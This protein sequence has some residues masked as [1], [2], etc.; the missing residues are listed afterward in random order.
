MPR[1][2][3]LRHGNTFDPGEVVTR[4]GGRTDPP[5]SKSGR[6]Q[7]AAVAEALAGRG[8][9]IG[10]ILSSPLARAVETAEAVRA[11]LAPGLAIERAEALREIDYGPDEN[12]PEADVVAR[13]GGDAL[14]AW[15]AHA[16]PA[17]GWIVDPQSLIAA[18]RALFADVAK[19][20]G[21]TLAVTSNGVARFA[22]DAADL[23]PPDAPRR[24]KTAAFGIVE[25]GAGPCRVTD[26]NLPC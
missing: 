20:S 7:S 13:V 26:W 18:W 19:A 22:L 23:V 11:R 3:I 21:D 10:R 6:A 9:A 25:A 15:D 8:F 14:A 16:I 17:P 12:K 1:L 5:L 2:I 24:L 4:V